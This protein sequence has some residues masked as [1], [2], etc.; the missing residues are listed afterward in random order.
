[1]KPPTAAPTIIVNDEPRPLDG[2]ATVAALAAELGV[3]ERKGVA[4]A[5]NG[6]VVPRAHWPAH[7]L[8]EGDR[9]LVIRA[10]QGG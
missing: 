7:A 5:V 3:G 8:G 10:T 1:M 9:V 6:G 4:I 2:A